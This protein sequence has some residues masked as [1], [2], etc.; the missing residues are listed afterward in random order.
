MKIF[1][2]TSG[3]G[4][5]SFMFILAVCFIPLKMFAQTQTSISNAFLNAFDSERAVWTYLYSACNTSPTI[6]QTVLYGDTVI[7]GTNWKIITGEPN[8]EKGL[9]RTDGRRV[10]LKPYP[11]FESWIQ[12]NNKEEPWNNVDPIIIYDFSLEKGDSVILGGEN[13]FEIF[14]IDSLLLNDSY[15]HKRITYG[16]NGGLSSIIEGLGS[17]DHT[18]LYGFYFQTTCSSGPQLVCCHV[19]GEL[20]YMHPNYLD[21]DGMPVSN[22]I[23]DDISLKSRIKVIDDCLNVMFD[24]D[25]N[26]DVAVYSMQGIVVTQNKANFNVATIPLNNLPQGVYVAKITSGK[27]TDSHKFVK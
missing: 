23:I 2:K 12:Y 14:K 19:D 7:D 5:I 24:D 26:F 25:A 21:C 10:L 18:P 3:L 22:E 11:G 1:Y 15:K 6:H 27:Y 8:L 17:S 16:N 13:K 20:L 4:I 9:V